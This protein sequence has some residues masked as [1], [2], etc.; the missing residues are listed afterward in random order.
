VKVSDL[1]H[2]REIL[3]HLGFKE[4][5]ANQLEQLPGVQNFLGYDHH[6]DKFVHVHAHSRLILGHDLSKNYH[7]PIERPY[8]ES[9]QTCGLF[10]IPAPEFE[11][12]IF[13]IRMII[14]HATLVSIFMNYG[15]LSKIEEQELVYLENKA[16]PVKVAEILCQYIP[17]IDYELFGECLLAV[18]PNCPLMIRIRA[19]WRLHERLK[20]HARRP[21]IADLFTKLGRRFYFYFQRHLIKNSKKFLLTNG[22]AIVAIVGG[23]GAGKTT[24]V[25]EL[26][27]WLS[28][29]LETNKTHLG[30]PSWSK[31]TIIVRAL[32]KAGNILRLYPFETAPVQYGEDENAYDFP[33]FPWLIRQACT[34]RD[35]FL[36]YKRARRF[37]SNGGI[38][39]CDRYPI[40]QIR[41][42]ESPSVSIRMT[43]VVRNNWVVKFLINLE[44]KFN[45]QILLPDVL[46]VLR[47]DPATAI[48]RKPDEDA[49]S[50]Q[51][52]N[53][54]IWSLDWQHTYARIIDA[55]QP[56]A[57][58]LSKLK[59]LVWSEL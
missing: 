4:C 6:G 21:F 52:R 24:A 34:A 37:A 17:F 11:F 5:L 35:R 59:A 48:E 44:T 38:M 23:D 45:L 1:Q 14:K 40:Q 41:F 36:A 43:N 3:F 53:K 31:I 58:V 27:S 2:F 47:L 7:L 22:G 33:G 56:K 8:L 15:T 13:V 18:R 46:I 28:R 26:N 57:E 51:A 54:E 20:A 30:K 55:N 29:Y 49:V 16:N 39:I 9:R 32:L 42:M 50:V 12:I 25:N 10:K 19:G